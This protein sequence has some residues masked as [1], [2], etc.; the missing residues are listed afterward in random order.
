[1]EEYTVSKDV[2]I[3]YRY[4]KEVKKKSGNLIAGDGGPFGTFCKLDTGDKNI[5]CIN[6]DNVITMDMTI[7]E[8]FLNKVSN[9]KRHYERSQIEHD[10]TL[11]EFEKRM[12]L[13]KNDDNGFQ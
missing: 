13:E 3:T 1:M 12:L 8:M 9:I 6:W 10:M 2:E 7:P 5:F 11:V 4:G